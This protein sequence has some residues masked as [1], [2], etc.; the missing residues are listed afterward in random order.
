MAYTTFEDSCQDPHISPEGDMRLCRR[1]RGH[2]TNGSECASGY[3][4]IYWRRDEE[5][6]LQDKEIN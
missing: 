1:T 3:P 4:V 5:E 2:W 6:I